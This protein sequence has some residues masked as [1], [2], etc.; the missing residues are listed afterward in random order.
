MTLST[1]LTAKKISTFPGINDQPKAP[2]AT[3]AGNGSHLIK[4]FNDL[5]DLLSANELTSSGNFI[6]VLL[7]SIDAGSDVSVSKTASSTLLIKEKKAIIYSLLKL[8]VQSTANN[9]L[10]LNNNDTTEKIDLSLNLDNLFNFVS[11]YFVNGTGTTLTKTVESKTIAVNSA[12]VDT[13][14]IYPLIKTILLPG[15]NTTVTPSDT[16]KTLT[17]ASTASGGGSSFVPE[18]MLFISGKGIINQPIFKDDLNQK[19]IRNGENFNVNAANPIFGV[20]TQS[21]WSFGDSSLQYEN[22][23]LPDVFGTWSIEFFIRCSGGQVDKSILTFSNGFST[24][25]SGSLYARRVSINNGNLVYQAKDTLDP[26]VSINMQSATNPI[27]PNTWTYCQLGFNNGSLSMR[28]GTTQV[29]T[30]SE[31]D[32]SEQKNNVVT[33]GAHNSDKDNGFNGYIANIRLTMGVNKFSTIVPTGY[34]AG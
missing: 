20:N 28:V 10:T 24:N 32:F 25:A 17:V 7:G 13:T 6:D 33:L 26:N 4:Q 11:S 34:F 3:E 2:I 27:S 12:S 15:T 16:N 21:L 8:I 18:T 19:L 29:A 23:F 31:G 9:G 14:I 5:I 1:D 30:A 22:N